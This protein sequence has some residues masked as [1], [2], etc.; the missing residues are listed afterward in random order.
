MWSSVS[1]SFLLDFPTVTD[2][3][4]ELWAQRNSFI[5]QCLCQGIY[6]SNRKETKT[7]RL[8]EY[9]AI[10]KVCSD[11]QPW[12][13]PGTFL[14][15]NHGLQ[16]TL[17]ISKSRCLKSSVFP[18]VARIC[19]AHFKKLKMSSTLD[20]EQLLK[21]R[22]QEQ[23]TLRLPHQEFSRAVER[24]SAFCF[25]HIQQIWDPPWMLKREP[26]Y[27]RIS[28]LLLEQRTQLELSWMARRRC[29]HSLVGQTD[30]MGLSP[31]TQ[32]LSVVD[33]LGDAP[34][35]LLTHNHST[36]ITTLIWSTLI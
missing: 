20:L 16:S 22:N 28:V 13:Q 30:S 15:P 19:S 36:H 5:I 17:L 33:M 3:Y 29:A 7:L 24:F 12:H 26:S 6:T 27:Q 4:L 18:R 1:R 23:K 11:Q 2:G 32:L 10:N 35:R 31:R 34:L 25:S 14:K 8:L 9:L 21:I